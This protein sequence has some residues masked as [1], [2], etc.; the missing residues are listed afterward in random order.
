MKFYVIVRSNRI[1]VSYGSC[2]RSVFWCQIISLGR[3]S[4]SDV[5]GWGTGILLSLLLALCQSAATS[6]TQ[7]ELDGSYKASA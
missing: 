3:Q 2:G 7:W 4:V 1:E 6:E 5:F